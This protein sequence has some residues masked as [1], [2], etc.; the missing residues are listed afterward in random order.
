MT[1]NVKKVLAYAYIFYAVTAIYLP[2][3]KLSGM[4]GILPFEAICVPISFCLLIFNK[5]K[6]SSIEK[7]YFWY[8]A[9]SFLSWMLWMIV[10][11]SF[12]I[13]GVL[14]L[15]KYASF[16]LLIPVAFYLSTYLTESTL[17]KI[18]Y[19][20]VLFVVIA[21][22]YTIY[23]TM[24]GSLTALQLIGGYDPRYRLIGLTGM[25][26]SFEGMV[27][28]GNTSVQMGVYIAVLFLIFFSLYLRI[29][30]TR[31]LLISFILFIGLLLTYSRSGFV[32]M[33]VGIAL[34]VILK[35]LN[36]RV[37]KILLITVSTVFLLT[38]FFDFWTFLTSWGS[39]AKLSLRGFEDV[40]RVSY[41][42]KGLS[43]ILDNPVKI[44]FGTGFHSIF[45]IFGL[46]TLE[47]LFMD[48]LIESGVF[49]LTFLLLFYMH[50]WKYSIKYS[51][52][53]QSQN[54]FKAVLYGYYLAIPGIFIASTVGGNSIQVDLM[55]PTFFLS[56]GICL[57]HISYFNKRL[58]SKTE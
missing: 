52:P 30:K 6:F 34:V 2:K 33:S 17:K 35:F 50:L 11:E 55:A 23:H 56:F 44:I 14:L 22:G 27:K 8:V 20:Q 57:S 4:T 31:D 29:K 48:T 12:H 19:S 41:W 38:V 3:I 42:M 7:S 13:E 5:L 16:I 51:K 49:G 25:A 32:V 37:F 39:F 24:Y 58:S 9:F 46:G 47:S 15:F 54:Y 10:A 1:I 45:Y 28:L 43:Y 36:R 21:G 18:L 26:I 53:F 40:T